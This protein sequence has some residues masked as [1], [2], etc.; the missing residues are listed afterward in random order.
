MCIVTKTMRPSRTFWITFVA[1]LFATLTTSCESSKAPTKKEPAEIVPRELLGPETLAIATVDG[2]EVSL[3]RF[4]TL[5]EARISQF[6]KRWQT[7]KIPRSVALDIKTSIARQL[8]DELLLEQDAK[9]KG[10]N[11]ADDDVNE[12]LKQLAATFP[13][14][15]A[16]RSYISK[17]PAG[18]QGIRNMLRMRLIKER[19]AGVDEPEPVSDEETQ[20]FYDQNSHLFNVPAHLTVQ[21]IVYL[22]RPD[23]TQEKD[24]AQKAKAE[25]T[26]AEAQKP[27]ISFS[28]LARRHSE[29][30]SAKVGGQ[31]GRVTDKSIDPLLW[32]V[33][34][35]M[36]PQQISEVIR[37]EDG[38]HILKLIRRNPE[39]KRSFGETKEDIRTQIQSRRRSARV[40][41]LMA[42]LRAAAQIENHIEHRYQSLIILTQEMPTS[43]LIVTGG[44][45]AIDALPGNVPIKHD[46][47]TIAIR[48]LE[49]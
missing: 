16:F 8:I 23:D 6:R 43:N 30:E 25:G 47:A 27:S 28:S 13:S 1:V 11:V 21:D 20:R 14:S 15:E 34:E 35:R 38:Y 7:T 44:E 12:A 10:V 41:E 39:I 19:L 45:A 9:R 5:Y 3:E 26:L 48:P 29:G 37:A 32:D 2:K 33:L 31:L 24:K 22:V 46:S 49:P 40:A 36:K 42:K 17:T 4:N 18:E